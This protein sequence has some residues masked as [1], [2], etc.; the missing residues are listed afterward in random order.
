[1]ASA[2]SLRDPDAAGISKR[3]CQ[4]ELKKI[5]STSKNGLQQLA[6]AGMNAPPSGTADLEKAVKSMH[7]I[8]VYTCL[9]VPR[10]VC[11]DAI[12]NSPR[13]W[14]RWHKTLTH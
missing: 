4:A 14:R 7:Q 2:R 3:D 12:A 6:A 13:R 5:V 10:K 11:C 1:M 8:V 9:Y